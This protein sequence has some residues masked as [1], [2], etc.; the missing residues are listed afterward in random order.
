VDAQTACLDQAGLT[1][2]AS[3]L[4]DAKTACMALLIAKPDF[5]IWVD[6]QT[7]AFDQADC[8]NAETAQ[9]AIEAAQACGNPLQ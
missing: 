6:C 9:G 7:A 4:E 3:K 2:D 5:G 1:Y 8:S